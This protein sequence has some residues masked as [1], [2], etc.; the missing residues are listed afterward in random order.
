[1]DSNRIT[2]LRFVPSRAEGLPDV[3]EVA[4]FPDRLEV[5][6]AGE[7]KTFRFA[8]IARWPSPAWLRRWQHRCGRRSGRA[9]NVGGRSWSGSPQKRYFVFNT[10]PRLA[11]RMPVDDP[12]TYEESHFL[13][14]KQ[15]LW[16]GGFDTWDLG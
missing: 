16:Q 5:N 1:M 3:R 7:W 14:I 15:V 2:E 10:T 6:T 8:D 12:Q 4:I 13:R 11:V 9:P